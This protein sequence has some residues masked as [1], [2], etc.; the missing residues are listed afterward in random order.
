MDGKNIKEE[1]IKKV[2]SDLSMNDRIV[3]EIVDHQFEVAREKMATCESIEFS[4][5]VRFHFNRKRAAQKME[6]WQK[7]LDFYIPALKNEEIPQRTRAGYQVRMLDIIAN[8]KLLKEKMENY[9]REHK[10]MD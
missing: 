7:Y 2:A 1:I 4:G 8:M 5:F 3:R 9:D 6:K 10:K